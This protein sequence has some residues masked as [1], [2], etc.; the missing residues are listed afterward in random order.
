MIT[1][2]LRAAARHFTSLSLAVCC[3]LPVALPAIAQ[4]PAAT[5]TQQ[6]QQPATSPAA[7]QTPPAT[8]SIVSRPIPLRSVGL[9]PSKVV[10]WTLRDAVTA[11]LAKNVDIELERENVRLQQYDLIA[12]QGFYDPAAVS[13]IQ[14]NRSSTPNAFRFSGTDSS[15]ISRDSV[16]FNGGLRKNFERYGTSLQADFNNQRLGSNT[17]NLQVQYSPAFTASIAQPLFRNFRIDANRRLIK[18]TK[19]RLDLSDAVFRQRVIEII[20]QV[21]QA[22]WDLALAIRNEGIGRESVGLA[23]TQLN[24]NKRQV[25]VG[26]LAPIDVVSAATQ[27]E[28]RRQQVFQA[29]NQVA[30]A[31][32]TLKG[33]TVSGPNDDL[34]SAR[35]EPVESFNIA[36]VTLP[37]DDAVRLAQANRP[38]IKQFGFQKEI[39]QID[40]DFYR[41]QAKPQIDLIAAY[42]T[43][44][45]GGTPA[46]FSGTT[47]N[48]SNPVPLIG[49]DG[50]VDLTKLFCVTN[51]LQLVNGTPTIIP[52]TA[53][54]FTTT[55]V[56]APANVTDQFVGSYGT[57]LGNLFRNEFRTISFGVQITLPLRNRTAKANLAKAQET[58]RQTDLQARRLLQNIEVDVRN[59]VQSVETAKMRIEAAKA[60]REYAQQQLEGEEKKFAAGLSTTFFILQRQNDLSQAQYSELQALADYN[61]SVATLQRVVSTT[62]S[63]NGVEIQADTPV[64]I[65]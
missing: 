58:I 36:P 14:Y 40:V 39:N 22:Y 7:Q 29:I 11:A 31:E 25:E 26:T 24:N 33:L 21:Q 1:K 18:L 23:E 16:T 63:S 46:S 27:V 60:A 17:N 43:N 50:K 51:G 56:A 20:S 53:V 47:S 10:R 28:T 5:P 2:S 65:K 9:D 4:D 54:P 42:T 52:Q 48:C 30:L 13:T 49:S 59:A 45:L 32:N 37:L 55:T 8:S 38:E 19:K 57:A 61:K 44:G 6:Q 35:I 15:A 64:T 41:N 62:L 3:T 34:W 12:A